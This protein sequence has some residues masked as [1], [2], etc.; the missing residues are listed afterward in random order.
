MDLGFRV[1]SYAVFHAYRV[2]VSLLAEATRKNVT[3]TGLI[4]TA[5]LHRGPNCSLISVS[6]A[7]T[8][9]VVGA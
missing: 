7:T 4:P 2:K 8:A 9:L 5:C 6:A 3:P 1:R